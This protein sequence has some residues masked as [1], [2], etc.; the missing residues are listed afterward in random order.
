MP[1]G[2]IQKESEQLLENLR[3]GLTLSVLSDCTEKP[4]AMWENQNILTISNKKREA[5]LGGKGIGS[6][7]NGINFGFIS[8]AL[9][10]HNGPLAFGFELTLKMLRQ[11]LF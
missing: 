4:F 3:E 11:L 5:A 7:L 1:A 8:D 6:N 2:T 10:R 9:L